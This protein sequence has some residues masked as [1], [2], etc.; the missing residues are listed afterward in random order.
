MDIFFAKYTE[1]KNDQKIMEKFEKWRMQCLCS[2]FSFKFIIT[3]AHISREFYPR[4]A[5]IGLIRWLYKYD[6]YS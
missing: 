3:L 6:Q 5:D 4:Q 1:S 2:N